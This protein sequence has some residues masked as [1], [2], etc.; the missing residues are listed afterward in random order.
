MQKNGII[1]ANFE[2]N[3]YFCNRIEIGETIMAIQRT[4][5]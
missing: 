3:A 2:E 1:L 5:L 4:T